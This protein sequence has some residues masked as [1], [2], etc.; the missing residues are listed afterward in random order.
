ML[1]KALKAVNDELKQNDFDDDDIEQDEEENRMDSINQSQAIPTAPDSIPPTSAIE[2]DM[3]AYN[4]D[5]IYPAP[6]S[7]KTTMESTQKRKIPR[8]GSRAFAE[9]MKKDIETALQQ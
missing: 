1:Q 4:D 5:L 8:V 9:T 2:H 6:P 7:P 3:S